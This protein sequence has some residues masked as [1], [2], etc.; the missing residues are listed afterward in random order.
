MNVDIHLL[1]FLPSGA[2]QHITQ[3][4]AVRYSFIYV[5]YI[6]YMYMYIA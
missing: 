5:Y 3:H 4:A 2:R 1:A 6:L